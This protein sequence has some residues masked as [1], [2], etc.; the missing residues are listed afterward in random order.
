MFVVNVV[1]AFFKTTSQRYDDLPDVDTPN[2]EMKD[3]PWMHTAKALM[4]TD[5]IR[6]SGNNSK[7]IGWAKQFGGF[8]KSYYTRDSIPWCGLFEAHIMSVNPLG[9]R[10]WLKFGVECEP[11][12]GAVMVF[13]RGKK[14]GW[15]GHVG[16]YVSEDA[17][18]YHI[19]GGNQSDSVNVTKVAKSRFL[20]ARWPTEFPDVR[21]TFAGRIIKTFDGKVSTNEQ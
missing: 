18:Y 5:E 21:K 19:L 9:A 1:M 12:Y 17:K 11:Q 6:G 10:N 16:N 7:I 2:D 3:I 8:L 15:S 14:S 13:W 20:G 4:G